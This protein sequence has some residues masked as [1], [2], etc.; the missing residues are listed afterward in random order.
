MLKRYEYK[1]TEKSGKLWRRKNAKQAIP[2]PLCPAK[3]QWVTRHLLQAH[4]IQKDEAK[5]LLSTSSS[6]RQKNSTK[7]KPRQ[8]CPVNG[9][10]QHV[11]RLSDH[12]RRKHNTTATKL[13]I[14]RKQRAVVVPQTSVIAS[15]LINMEDPTDVGESSLTNTAVFV[16][17]FSPQ[18]KRETTELERTLDDFKNYMESMDAGA[19]QHSKA[20]RL[21]CKHI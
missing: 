5:I 1:I 6:Y 10:S 9:C 8:Q 11:I 19:K 14:V 16:R 20:Y 21:S 18:N 15:H 3:T 4:K 2:C 7:L 13:G 17:E 12:L